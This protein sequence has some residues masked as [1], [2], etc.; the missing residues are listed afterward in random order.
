LP[1]KFESNL[2][3]LEK[4]E[5]KKSIILTHIKFKK[6]NKQYQ[7]FVSIKFVIQIEHQKK[8][9]KVYGEEIIQ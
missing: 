4:E 3:S 1:V 6:C 5:R 9:Y 7:S 2:L 8:I